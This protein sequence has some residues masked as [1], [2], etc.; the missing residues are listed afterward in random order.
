MT[1]DK[2]KHFKDGGDGTT[3]LMCNRLCVNGIHYHCVCGCS[4]IFDRKSR[5]IQHLSKIK[6]QKEQNQNNQTTTEVNQ[7]AEGIDVNGHLSEPTLGDSKDGTSNDGEVDFD[8]NKIVEK[9]NFIKGKVKCSQ[10]DKTMYKKN[11]YM[12]MQEGSRK[13]KCPNA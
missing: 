5:L 12:H 6:G 7:D 4:K 11:L 9:N 3:L 2:K 13:E 10:C 8:V 1:C